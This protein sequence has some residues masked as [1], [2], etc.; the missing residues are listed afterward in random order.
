MSNR[1]TSWSSINSGTTQTFNLDVG[2]RSVGQMQYMNINAAPLATPGQPQGNNARLLASSLGLLNDITSVQPFKTTTYDGLQSQ[3]T[4]RLGTSIVGA[5]YTWS[6]AINWAG[7]NGNP[8]IQWPGAWNL[9]R[10]PASYDHTHNLQTYF[11]LESPFGKGKRWV[12]SG[13][14]SHLLSGWE[15]NGIQCSQRRA[16]L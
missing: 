6:K 1:G 9:N 8:R 5:T 15:I 12:Q 3:V 10:G 11:A 14:A 2:T 4:H 13:F 7:N 16:H